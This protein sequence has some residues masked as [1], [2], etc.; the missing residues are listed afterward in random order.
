MHAFELVIWRVFN[1]VVSYRLT[2]TTQS[3]GGIVKT[4]S[5]KETMARIQRVDAS[6]MD[7]PKQRAAAARELTPEQRER[8]R[9]Q[10]Q[11]MRTIEQLQGA[12][13]VFEVR[14]GKGEKPITVRQR[15]LRAAG[16]ANKEVAV[17]RSPNGFLVGL[18]TPERRSNRGRKKTSAA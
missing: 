4:P 13:D 16:D 12:A 2:R 11:F 5:R 15:L 14:L 9:Q 1:R 3:G 18:M 17:R 7:A 10:R 6:V 8:E